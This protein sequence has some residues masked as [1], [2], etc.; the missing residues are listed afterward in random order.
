[1]NQKK[2]T[3]LLALA[4][5]LRSV[6]YLFSK[7]GL[8]EMQPLSLLAIRFLMGFSILLVIFHKQI[9]KIRKTTFF[10]GAALGAVFFICMAFELY[11][12]RVT[13]SSETA[14]LENTAIVFV[15]L[16]AAI[17]YRKRPKASSLVSAL[18]AL[19]GVG[20]L[21][22]KGGH[23]HFSAGELLC[24]GA[25]L[26]YAAVI[27]MMDSFSKEEDPLLLGILQNGFIGL[28]A[29]PAAFLFESPALP[30]S[31]STWGSLMVLVIVCTVIGFTL[32]PIAQKD[33]TAE[34]AG[35]LCALNPLVAMVLG[36]TIL[37]ERLEPSGVIGVAC[38]IG[39]ILTAELLPM[40]KKMRKRHT[41][42]V[43]EAGRI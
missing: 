10:K 27:L 1:M 8:E 26:S 40:V 35:L 41:E 19:T 36:L 39:S 11:G 42:I 24:V 6:S 32:Q 12:L 17:V 29:L 4:I 25:A 22:L 15:P 2:G 43:L 23:L 31:G 14:F 7:S 3:L 28:F 30:K 34:Q 5:S 16:F 38:I 33:T 21:T 18:I 9:P 37:H 13:S 20:L